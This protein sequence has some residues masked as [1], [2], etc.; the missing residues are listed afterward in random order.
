MKVSKAKKC[1]R[2]ISLTNLNGRIDVVVDSYIASSGEVF[3]PL[4]SQSLFLGKRIFLSYEGTEAEN[5][6]N[7][8]EFKGSDYLQYRGAEV[9]ANSKGY[10]T[11]G[12]VLGLLRSYRNLDE[13]FLPYSPFDL[14]NAITYGELGYL[15]TYAVGGELPKLGTYKPTDDRMK[16]SIISVQSQEGKQPE[17]RLGQYT[18]SKVFDDYLYDIRLGSRPVPVPLYYGYMHYFSSRGVSLLG[19]VPRDVALEVIKGV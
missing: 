10:A 8:Q 17:Y 7:Y 4:K 11:R 19:E 3:R 2:A 6:K 12:S 14:G 15:M 5:D 1:Y 9:V 18:S 16:L 13:D